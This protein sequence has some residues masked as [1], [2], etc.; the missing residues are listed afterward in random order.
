[1]FTREEDVEAHAL[2]SR[3]WSISAIARHLGRDRKTIRAHLAGD[4]EPGVR[5][6]REDDAFER[7]VPYV[8]QRLADDPH[9][10]ASVL[11]RELR[12]LEFVAS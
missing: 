3:G 11:E 5:A 1:M 10:R 2:R 8:R 6:R 9:L 4:R 7:L 12:D